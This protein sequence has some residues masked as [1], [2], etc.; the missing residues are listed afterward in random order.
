MGTGSEPLWQ[1]FG[2]RRAG[3][4][5]VPI[6]SQP[7]S[8]VR[9]FFLAVVLASTA[10]LA[11][12]AVAADEV[13]LYEED[14][15]DRITLNQQN[16]GAVLKVR[17]LEL[18]GRRLPER[19]R[20]GDKLTVQ[21]LDQPDKTYEVAWEAIAKVELF[22]QIV[23]AKANELVAAGKLDE[24]FDYFRYLEEK[25]PRLA[26]LGKGA[27]DYLYEE[28]KLSHRKQQYES[29][30]AALQELC[31]RNRQRPG[32]DNALGATTEKLIEQCAAAED[33]AAARALLHGLAATFPGHP[34]VAK[35][36]EL[37][38][39]QA[40]A[41]LA[42][43]RTAAQ[44]G[45]LRKAAE[46]G[47]RATRVWPALAGAKAW[48]ES[49]HQKYPRVVVGVT[50]PA[51]EVLPGR[52]DDW[53]SR[54]RSRLVYRTLTELLGPGP[55]GGKYLCPV[56]QISSDES[57][58]RLVVQLRPGV[59][60]SPGESGL[61]GYELSRQLL[62]MAD[63][64]ADS[65]RADWAELLAGV[66]VPEVYRLEVDLRRPHVR[67]E[68]LLQ[69]LLVPANDASAADRRPPP[70]NG[71]YIVA[72]QTGTDTICVQNG[73]YF[74]ASSG[75]PKEIVERH[76]AQGGAAL[77][78]LRRGDVQVLDRVN[79]WDLAGLRADKDLVIEPYGVPLIHC[80]VPN[81]RKPLLA[82]RGFR[83]ALM[84]G[85]DRD[86]ILR[87]LLAGAKLPGCRVISGPLPPGVDRGDPLGY[88]YDPEIA[89][90]RWEPRLAIALAAVAY[91]EI[92]AAEK[93][94]QKGTDNQKAR[95]PSKPPAPAATAEKRSLPASKTAAR[96]VL[97]HPPL[98]A[99]RVACAAIKRHL[100]LIGIP[101]TLKELPPTGPV[102]MTDDV[103][104]LFVELAVWEPLV[105]ARRLLGEGGIAPACSPAMSL[106]LRQLD[107][108]TDWSQAQKG[109][110]R[111]HRIA[112]DELVLL[113]LWQW[114]EQFAYR[115]SLQ[116]I[117]PRPMTLYQNV[118]AWQPGFEFPEEQ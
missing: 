7:R 42:Q 55:E 104:L 26:G 103:D 4:V 83:R 54:R 69:T 18:P 56:G 40:A 115:A 30:L 99:A 84:Y 58:R 59:R 5:P 47:R 57:G 63:P 71:P 68:A 67:P 49:L 16:Q 113:P 105:D 82:D 78:A 35:W 45:E 14:P 41:L 24:A 90:R 96:L 33:Y 85:I 110:Y 22:E 87:Q 46:L 32:L 65:F 39:G 27:E 31:R 11:R 8:G 80:L 17:P 51:A 70:A 106:A 29:A 109:L 37:W 107:Q 91:Q 112:H 43:S 19:P 88:A 94:K 79:P 9:W 89:P 38:Q 74:A 93:E 48:A 101:I 20:P 6:F 60:R 2:K 61:T 95:E 76:F 86:A 117:A 97:A 66:A 108:A 10:L 44:A 114:T 13:P 64:A 102:T 92:A 116:G 77:R 12:V 15:F 23:L 28:A 118:E 98:D 62:A 100:E 52:L 50:L 3:E 81:L 34:V 36:E 53:A 75:Q 73:Q 25:Y 72:G 111:I 21:L 1:R